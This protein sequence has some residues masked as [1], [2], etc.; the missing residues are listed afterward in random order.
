VEAFG[1]PYMDAE[2][3]EWACFDTV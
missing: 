2:R 1:M 3:G